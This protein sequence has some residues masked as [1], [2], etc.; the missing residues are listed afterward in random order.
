MGGNG[1]DEPKGSSFQKSLA[2]KQ[3]AFEKYDIW[4][5]LQPPNV[6]SIGKELL[7]DLISHLN[8]S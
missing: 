6:G 7:C 8:C 5:A 4:P 1:L 3:E 2:C